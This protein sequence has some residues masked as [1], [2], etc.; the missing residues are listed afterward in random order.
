MKYSYVDAIKRTEQF[1]VYLANPG[2]VAT[3]YDWLEGDRNEISLKKRPFVGVRVAEVCFSSGRGASTFMQS[4]MPWGIAVCGQ[5]ERCILSL[6]ED[7]DEEMPGE[8]NSEFERLAFL[9]NGGEAA[10][11]IPD[12]VYPGKWGGVG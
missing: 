1:L 9:I 11:L 12:D 8:I 2:V 5:A 4:D 6:I 10:K 7:W 3:I